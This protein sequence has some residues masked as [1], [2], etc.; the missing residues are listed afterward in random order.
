MKR[1]AVILCF[2]ILTAC[3]AGDENDDVQW[4]EYSDSAVQRLEYSNIDYEVKDGQI[5][6][7]EKDVNK[8]QSCCS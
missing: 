1:I 2:V 5:F 8:A 6:I 3:S 7:R 4:G